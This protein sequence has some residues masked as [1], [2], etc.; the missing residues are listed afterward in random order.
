MKTILTIL[1]LAITMPMMAQRMN[2]GKTCQDWKKEYENQVSKLKSELNILKKN[3]KTSTN[4]NIK[5][6]I[7]KKDAE[8][9]K[10]KSNLKVAKKAASLEKKADKN[11]SKA[12]S[13]SL[14]LDTKNA[15]INKKITKAKAKETKAENKVTKALAKLQKEQQNLENIKKDIEILQNNLESLQTESN[16]AKDILDNTKSKKDEAKRLLIEGTVNKT[17]IP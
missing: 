2:D 15:K 5:A 7:K 13:K 11:F 14:K 3:A 9:K 8:L 4:S 1:A 6:E 16:L 12:Q 10:A 17:P